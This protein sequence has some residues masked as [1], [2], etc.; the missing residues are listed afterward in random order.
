MRHGWNAHLQIDYAMR[1][2][3]TT[4][5]GRRHSGPLQVQKPLYPEGPGVCQT[6]VLHPPG[7]IVGGDCLDIKAGLSAGAHTLITTPGAAKWYCSDGCLARQTVHLTVADGALLEWLPQETIL[8]DGAY[9]ELLTRIDLSGNASFLGWEISCLGRTASG[10]RFSK[11][12][13]RQST[14]IRRDGALLWGEYGLLEGSDPLLESPIGLA[15][16]PVTATFLAVDM[17]V[18]EELRDACRLVLITDGGAERCGI[19]VFPE[20]LV[21]RYL[22]RSSERARLYFTK[23]WRLLRPWFSGREACPPRIWNT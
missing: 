20:L 14:E 8:F 2:G 1:Q 23:L 5:V 16:Y 6:I 9:A 4:L 19:T 17:K 7:G 15:G 13:W 3:R 22:G 12:I 11:G 10:E 18:T 21:A